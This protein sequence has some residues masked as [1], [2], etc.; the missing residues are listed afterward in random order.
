MHYC[1]LYYN[2]AVSKGI[3]IIYS[4]EA[5]FRK[6]YLTVIM[7]VCQLVWYVGYYESGLNSCSISKCKYN[8]ISEIAV[9]M[10]SDKANKISMY[11]K[12]GQLVLMY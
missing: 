5:P 11:H 9:M 4:Q 3:C 2:W 7:S 10:E 12:Q 8:C 6:T 1:P